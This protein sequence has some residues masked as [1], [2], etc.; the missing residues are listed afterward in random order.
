[1]TSAVVRVSRSVCA[2][3]H[4]DWR[5]RRFC[6]TKGPKSSFRRQAFAL[7]MTQ[8]RLLAKLFCLV[9]RRPSLRARQPCALQSSQSHSV[10]FIR[11]LLVYEP[12]F[13]S[14]Q[15][16]TQ[17]ERLEESKTFDWG[18]VTNLS[19]C[20]SLNLAP[21]K[22]ESPYFCSCTALR[23]RFVLLRSELLQRLAPCAV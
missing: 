21:N 18:T 1:M 8:F 15:P 7:R 16:T 20:R 10:L 11:R 22:L 5:S 9:E 6:P 19:S 3:Y 13:G 4:L 14:Q 2:L 23:A 17:L 12:I